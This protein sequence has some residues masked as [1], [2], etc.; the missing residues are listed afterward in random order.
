MAIIELT[1][2]ES[3]AVIKMNN[4]ENRHHLEFAQALQGMLEKVTEDET[5]TA[6][7]LTSTDEKNWSQGIDLE[8][9]MKQIG[10]HNTETIIEFLLT[11]DKVFK[12]LLTC[13]VPVIAAIN[14]HCFANAAIMAAACDF[15]FMRSD[16]GFY[17]L[18]EVDIN[19][20]F[21]PAMKTLLFHK[22]SNPIVNDLMLTGKRLTAPELEKANIIEKACSDTAETMEQTMAFAKMMQKQ[23]DTFGKMKTQI[24][25]SI[26]DDI[27][28]VNPGYFETQKVI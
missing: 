25:Q 8:W 10:D 12:I 7:I 27:D 6:V 14:G 16:R 1:M 24:N 9:M 26:I 17:C 3:I 13:P 18:P 20:Q 21:A 22:Y 5:V 15:R 2:D 28:N 4:G 23:R 19:I 11:M